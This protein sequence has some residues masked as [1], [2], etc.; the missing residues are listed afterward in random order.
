M[1]SVGLE[2]SAV[3]L[4]A[5]SEKNGTVIAKHKNLLLKKTVKTALKG[6]A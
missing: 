2:G 3:I 4:F 6:F 5:R 1:H